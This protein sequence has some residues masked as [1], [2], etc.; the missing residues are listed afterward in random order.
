MGKEL[1]YKL[2]VA[3][4]AALDAILADGEV[5]ALAVEPWRST[6]MKTTY[7]DTPDRRLAQLRWML[8]R[9]MEGEESVVCLKTPENEAHVRGEWQILSDAVDDAAIEGLLAQGAPQELRTLCGKAPLL[10]VCGAEFLRRSTMLVFPDASRAELAG[11]CGILHGAAEQLPFTELELELY[12]GSP[13]EML[14]LVQRLSA[15]YG[16]CEEPLSKA[17]RA[18]QLA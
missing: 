18:M 16:L 14:A 9:R 11:D 17:A 15:R 8:R 2:R 7:F 6:R 1:E 4:R 12:S 5:A 13:E 10:P 3:D